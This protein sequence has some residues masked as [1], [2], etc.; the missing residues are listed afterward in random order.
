MNVD[1]AK[2][3]F[4]EHGKSMHIAVFSAI[5]IDQDSNAKRSIGNN[6]FQKASTERKLVIGTLLVVIRLVVM[7][8]FEFECRGKSILMKDFRP[9]KS[10]TMIKILD[11]LVAFLLT[12][13]E[14]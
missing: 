10:N 12:S 14:L 13:Y 8:N 3:A 9:E 11:F 7:V 5:W 2:I 1:M 4:Q 6:P